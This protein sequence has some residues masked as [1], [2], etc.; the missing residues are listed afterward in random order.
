MLAI[1]DA[2]RE[3]SGVAIDAYPGGDG[4]EAESNSRAFPATAITIVA[5]IAEGGGD[6]ATIVTHVLRQAALRRLSG[7]DVRLEGAKTLVG[8]DPKPSDSW[9]AYLALAPILVIDELSK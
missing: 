5:K 1:T 7:L 6:S 9:L 3:A 8:S 2:L 4:N